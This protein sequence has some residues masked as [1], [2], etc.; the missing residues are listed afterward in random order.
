[1]QSNFE[2]MNSFR[3]DYSEPSGSGSGCG[4]GR[5]S[6]PCRFSPTSAPAKR[7]S[8]AVFRVLFISS[9]CCLMYADEGQGKVMSDELQPRMSSIRSERQRRSARMAAPEM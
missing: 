6:P 9:G 4:C 2:G 3:L 5:L 1:M 7:C 8:R